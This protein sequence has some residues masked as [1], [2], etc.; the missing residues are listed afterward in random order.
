M[1]VIPLKQLMFESLGISKMWSAIV[2]SIDNR[3]QRYRHLK[4][5]VGGKDSNPIEIFQDLKLN[6]L[7]SKGNRKRSIS[8]FLTFI[9]HSHADNS[10]VLW[11]SQTPVIISSQRS[12]RFWWS[13]Q[14]SVIPSFKIIQRF[15]EYSC[16]SKF[17][18]KSKGLE[19]SQTPV[20]PS[21]KIIPRYHQA[22]KL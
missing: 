4:I 2:V 20:I 11:S 18:D 8:C 22:P 7:T 9:F 6:H 5:W 10:K 12:S 3:L 13:S 14:T 1:V 19:V 17:S 16:N 21:S 15:Y